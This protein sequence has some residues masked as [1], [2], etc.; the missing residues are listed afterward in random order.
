LKSN[1]SKFFALF[2]ALLLPFIILMGGVRTLISFNSPGFQYRMIGFPEDSLG[3][4]RQERTRL[5]E[6]TMTFLNSNQGVESLMQLNDSKGQTVYTPSEIAH[7]QDVK[8]VIQIAS[9]VWFVI[10]GLSIAFLIWMLVNKSW[11]QIRHSF[12]WGAVL[13]ILLMI[14]VVVFMILSFNTLFEKFHAIFFP[15]GN[16]T[17]SATSSLIRLFPL[18]LWVNVFILMTAY[19]LLVSILLLVIFWPRRRVSN[20]SERVVPTAIP[21][22]KPTTNIPSMA[23]PVNPFLTEEKKEVDVMTPKAETEVLDPTIGLYPPEGGTG[24]PGSTDQSSKP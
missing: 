16:W 19:A 22:S 11:A 6:A 18:T 8:N 1:P 3:Y 4:T 7:L 9:M 2:I 5:A 20:V 14:A 17:F 24:L 12:F 23:T 15:Q 13:T 10:C 21:S